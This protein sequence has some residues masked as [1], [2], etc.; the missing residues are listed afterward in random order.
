MA[1]IVS[2]AASVQPRI[3]SARGLFAGTVL[4]GSI[5]LTALVYPP[6][7]F[8]VMSIVTIWLGGI[9]LRV[10]TRVL[11]LSLAFG[12][13]M[14]CRS[15]IAPSFVS[16]Y[17]APIA[18]AL[19][20]IS[21]VLA[22]RKMRFGR[23]IIP[24]FGL[25]ALVTLSSFMEANIQATMAGLISTILW[26]VVYATITN[27][28][29]DERDCFINIVVAAGCV[30][31][32]IAFGETVFASDIV[33]QNVAMAV[34]SPYLIRENRI[35]QSGLNRA[36]GTIGYPIPL[37][38]LLTV[39]AALAIGAPHIRKV[40]VRVALT[41]LLA[42]G[43]LLTGTRASI[44]AFAAATIIYTIGAILRSSSFFKTYPAVIACALGGYWS[45]KIGAGSEEQSDFSFTHRASMV[46]QAF[47]LTQL[48][49]HRFLLGSGL[50]S[51]ERL[52]AE[53]YLRSSGTMAIDNAFVM[54]L[55]VGGVASF[56]LLFYLFARSIYRST[57]VMRIAISSMAIF[58][59]FYDA[60][61]WHLSAF[62]FIALVACADSRQDRAIALHELRKEKADCGLVEAR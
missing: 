31:A 7:L 61:G 30:Q 16:T 17:P 33:R 18:A 39:C 43:A 26:F 15:T 56:G 14:L 50:N 29:Q 53:G 49:V 21:W 6:A 4:I 8:G 23:S 24:I 12:V 20:I 22:P 45:W 34:D 51:H 52:F 42:T 19:I 40:G 5:S 38:N 1:G 54:M 10:P 27:L 60:M 47:D 11:G 3:N 41:A 36:Q 35:L 28:E 13:L 62:L 44:L 57:G 46:Q 25:G 58:F 37:A 32:C 9:Y 59:F 55:I 2:T 48:P